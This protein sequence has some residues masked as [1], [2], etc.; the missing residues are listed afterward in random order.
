MNGRDRAVDPGWRTEVVVHPDEHSLAAAAARLFA[1]EAERAVRK[2]G[3]FMV[4]L[5]GGSTPRR[6]Y[7][8]LAA[9]PFAGEVPWDKVVVFWGDERCVDA[10]DPR[11]NETMARDVL[12]D[13]VPVSRKQVHPVGCGAAT[14]PAE[15]AASY[16]RLLRGVLAGSGVR[17]GAPA[18]PTAAPRGA[19]GGRAGLDLVLLGL[20]D[21]GHTASL[22]A[23]SDALD[24]RE[25]WVAVAWGG[26]LPRVTLTA[27]FIN[28][29][30]LV[31]FIV[32]GDD[33]AEA[34]SRVLEGSGDDDAALPARRI[35]PACGRLLWLLDRKAA[36]LLTPGLRGGGVVAGEPAAGAATQEGRS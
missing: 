19:G 33:K 21:D 15:A 27:S 18:P 35:R 25:N 34:V 7:R 2:R 28:L 9:A 11:R 36:A 17:R 6:T 5:A 1:D 24:E 13:R 26:G 20:G 32:A 22:F 8:A 12:L 3:R 30:E 29:A 16:E 10:G 14:A 31:V 4:A 23:G